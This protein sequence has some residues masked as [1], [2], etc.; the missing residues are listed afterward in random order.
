MD[1]DLFPT[2]LLAHEL[3]KNIE[4]IVAS[5][6]AK[7]NP[8]K[9]RFLTPLSA[10]PISRVTYNGDKTIVFFVDGSKCI[11][12]CSSEDKY[13]RQTAITYALV[14]RLF[15]KVDPN[16]GIVDGNGI[17]LKLK[18]IADAGFDQEKEAQEL[19]AKKAAAKAEHEARQKAEKEAAFKRRAEKR[20]DEILLERAAIN[21]ANA[22]EDSLTKTK[23]VINESQN[24]VKPQ[25]QTSMAYV[26][27][28]KRFADF[29]DEEKR[30]YWRYH[31]AKR[32]R[33]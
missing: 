3:V 16:T 14:K 23:I 33:N 17:G 15:G 8:V 19:K 18:K 6:P 10:I 24:K 7:Q 11:V 28:N 30:E 9:Q 4:D 29:T 5:I 20:A 22:K 1:I 25:P 13:D 12:K 32:S 27:P 26:R 2:T 31:N 21:I